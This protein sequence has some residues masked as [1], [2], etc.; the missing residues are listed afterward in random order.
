VINEKL[1]PSILIAMN[2]N[3]A[4]WGF[5]TGTSGS[6]KTGEAWLTEHDPAAPD[7]TEKR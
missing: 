5:T 2:V 7:I 3:P 6:E 4:P 1:V